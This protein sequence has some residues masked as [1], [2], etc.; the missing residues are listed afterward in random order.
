M[1][2]VG[3]S[4]VVVVLVSALLVATGLKKQPGLGV[5]GAIVLVGL[6]LAWRGEGVGMLGFTAP[7]S[8]WQTVVLALMLG[9]ALQLLAVA[10]LDPLIERWTGV[11]L[12][13]SVVEGVKG[14]GRAFALWML[15]VWLVVAPLEEAIF[16]GFLMTE[17]ARVVG[18][19]TWATVLNVV[20]ASV[21]FGLAHGYQGRSGVIGT[22]IIGVFLG[23]IFVASGFNLWL[24]ILTHGV[25]DTVGLALIATGTDEAVRRRSPW[26][27]GGRA[28]GPTGPREAPVDQASAKRT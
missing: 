17:I 4:L 20:L 24:A 26:R 13:H 1:D 9:T 27:L 10:L 8:W 5:L 23:W 7:A 3:V 16:R 18:T 14:N 25:V 15:V 21:V 12:D 22:G 11:P 6:L 19:S 2:S 28:G